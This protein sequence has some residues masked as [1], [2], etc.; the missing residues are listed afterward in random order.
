MKRIIKYIISSLLSIVILIL[1]YFIIANVVATKNNSIAKF[2]GY[3][4]SYVPTNS[5][6]PT[7]NANSTIIFDQDYKYDDLNKGDIIV[8]FNNEENIYVIHRIVD[9][10]ELG[11]VT[12]GDNNSI[13]DYSKET[14]DYY[15]ITSA[16]YIGKYTKT[17]TA[18]S[19]NSSLSRFLVIV[20]IVTSFG[21]I[22]VSEV[23]SI[24]KTISQNKKDD[25]K[26][27]LK[28]ELIEEIKEELNNKD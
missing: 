3:S 20:L 17:I 27:K 10:T 11:F 13:C 26:K 19:L 18:F 28:Q 6:E 12:K 7:I 22:V 21:F 16:N 1:L 9:K 24:K 25:D 15:Y 23:F 14:N 4:I 2:F 8:Y 5:M